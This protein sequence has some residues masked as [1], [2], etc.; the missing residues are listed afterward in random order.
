M[1]GATGLTWRHACQMVFSPLQFMTAMTRRH[2]DLTF[3]RLFGRRGY[4]LNHP[5]LIAQ[6]LIHE[7]DAFEKLPRQ[8]N[9]VRQIFGQG[10]LVTE[11]QRWK[12]DRQHLQ[13]AFGKPLFAGNIAATVQCT[14]RMLDRWTNLDQISLIQEMSRLTAEISSVVLVG[15][16]DPKIIDQLSEAVIY[17]SDEFSSEMNSVFGLPD[18]LPLPNKRRKQKSIKFYNDFFDQLIYNR[19]TGATRREDFLQYLIDQPQPA[20]TGPNFVRDQLLTILIAAYHASSMALVWIFHLLDTHPDVEQRLIDELAQRSAPAREV[21]EQ[22]LGCEY[23]RM[24]IAESLRLYPPAWSLFAR[25]SK[26]EVHMRGCQ[27]PAGG[28]FYISPFVTHRSERFF[29]EPL[30]FDPERFSKKRIHEIPEY[31]YFPFGLGGRSCIGS[32]LALDQ[33]QLITAFVIGRFLLRSR[34]RDKESQL[35]AKLSLRPKGNCLMQVQVSPLS[36]WTDRTLPAT[37]LMSSQ[38]TMA[39]EMCLGIP[40]D[41]CPAFGHTESQRPF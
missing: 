8:V 24:V 36:A 9:V 17:M 6:V 19:R 39:H 20:G 5:E 16:D 34:E 38:K 29:P 37:E 15:E 11:G 25:R 3:F 22:I 21:P 41:R 28:W 27:I 35:V 40:V 26:R 12:L 10:I 18:W 23:L 32:R 2:G 14:R 7:A 33:L 13:R 31:A 1:L 30:K 4:L